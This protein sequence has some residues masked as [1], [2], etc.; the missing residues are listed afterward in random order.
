MEITK[1]QHLNNE[2][3]QEQNSFNFFA[4]LKKKDY[5]ALRYQK[6]KEQLKRF[7]KICKEFKTLGLPKPK[8]VNGVIGGKAKENKTPKE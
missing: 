6:H 7:Y 1:S 2:L 3:A 5:D 8:L 4:K